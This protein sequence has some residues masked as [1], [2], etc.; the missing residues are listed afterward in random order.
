M[1]ATRKNFSEFPHLDLS[2]FHQKPAF[3]WET[4]AEAVISLLSNVCFVLVHKWI[5]FFFFEKTYELSVLLIY[6]LRL[7]GMP[8]CS[9][10][11]RSKKAENSVVLCL[12]KYYKINANIDLWGN[13]YK[14]K[15]TY[16]LL[17][18]SKRNSR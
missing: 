10:R 17:T 1:S 18:M 16:Y 12:Q 6:V 4:P 3:S 5:F 2:T 15:W 8:I 7:H 14:Y 9:S 11:E 13:F